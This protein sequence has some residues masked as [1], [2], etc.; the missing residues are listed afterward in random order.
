MVQEKTLI[1]NQQIYTAGNYLNSILAPI[2]SEQ[3]AGPG[4]MNP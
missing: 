3:C 4:G 1:L 2:K